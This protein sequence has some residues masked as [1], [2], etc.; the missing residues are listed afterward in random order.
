[1]TYGEVGINLKVCRTKLKVVETEYMEIIT[2]SSLTYQDLI[3]FDESR[4]ILISIFK[5]NIIN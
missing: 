2:S 5:E 3:S 4:V 1:M